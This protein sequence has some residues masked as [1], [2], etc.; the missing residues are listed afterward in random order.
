M[1]LLV[2]TESIYA[3]EYFS[4]FLFLFYLFRFTYFYS[5][6]KG[7]LSFKAIL[8]ISFFFLT[9]CG[10][11]APQFNK[12]ENP[13]DACREFIDGSL[14]GD[15]K[16]AKFY[17]INDSINTAALLKIEK[18]YFN[19][20]GPEKAQFYDASIIINEDATINDTIHII[21]YRNSYDK[22]DRKIKVINRDDTWLVD[23]KYTFNGNL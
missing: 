16:R 9:A 19:K 8:L 4:N 10:R 15:F 6:I 3:H 14:K 17:M 21:N 2:P 12:A 7:P 1:A 5:M 20:T 13:L 18:D 22:I 23:F 11:N